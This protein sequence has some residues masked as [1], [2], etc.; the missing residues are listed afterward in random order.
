[1]LLA[2][3]TGGANSWCM[4]PSFLAIIFLFY[5]LFIRSESKKRA[6]H[7]EMIRQLK[8]NDRVVT[9]GGIYGTVASVSQEKDEIVLR[10]DEN[11]NTKIRVSRRAIAQVLKDDQDSKDSSS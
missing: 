10:V 5:L 8:K 6:Q 3:E 7:E 2:A 9:I 1:M 11:T 4:L